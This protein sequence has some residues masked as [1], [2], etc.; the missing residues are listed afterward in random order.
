MTPVG[1]VY[2][3]QFFIDTLTELSFSEIAGQPHLRSIIERLFD[4]EVFMYDVF[5]RHIAQLH[6]ERG[7]I[8]IVILPVIENLTV[9]WFAETVERV[10]QCR[11]AR[12]RTSDDSNKFARRNVE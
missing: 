9:I 2:I 7:Q 11:F 3:L 6:T 4:S 1:F 12:A 10:Y 5:L 8:V